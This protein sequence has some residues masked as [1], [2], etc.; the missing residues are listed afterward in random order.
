MNQ[1]GTFSLVNLDVYYDH[2]MPVNM[3]SWGKLSKEYDITWKQA[4]QTVS[5]DFGTVV[6]DFHLENNVYVHDL[7]PVSAYVVQT[8]RKSGCCA[9]PH[10]QDGRCLSKRSRESY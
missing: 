4:E 10:D 5:V 6:L 9:K 1:M 2:K 7:K 3:L 8:R